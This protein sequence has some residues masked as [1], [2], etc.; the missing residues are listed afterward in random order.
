MS[1]KGKTIGLIAGN[2]QFPLIWCS[3]AK[4]QGFRVVAVAHLGETDKLLEEMA[5]SVTWVRLGE[6]GRIIETF[7]KAGV[8]EVA[9]AGGIKKKRIFLDARPDF[10]ALSVLA[11]VGPR[12]DDALLRA[13]A[14][15]LAAVGIKVNKSTEFLS[16]LL[17]PEVLMTARPLTSEE[18]KD[19]A[20]G[21]NLAK[22][23]G[24]LELG[25]CVVV[26]DQ[27]VLAVEAI[28]GTDETIRRGGL[29]AKEGAVVVK[30]CKNHQDT[31][32][33]LPTVGPDTIDVMA[34][35]GAR[36]LAVEAGKSIIL[37]RDQLIRKAN[38]AGM[39]VLGIKCG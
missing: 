25:Q 5:D 10:R 32:F 38:E 34:E 24:R 8:S 30:V 14:D 23:V 9:L 39:T 3:A 26:K 12:K 7:K 6:L 21:A 2:G 1:L 22:E 20:F 17:T 19:V 27:T 18:E 33:D 15:E 4:H 16:V 13:L 37:E 35:V 31:R 11:R 28:E 29:L 36:V